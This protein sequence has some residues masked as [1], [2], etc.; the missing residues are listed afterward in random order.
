MSRFKVTIEIREKVGKRKRNMTSLGKWCGRREMIK[1]EWK[2]LI[3]RKKLSGER[4]H[5]SLFFKPR[6][7]LTLSVRAELQFLSSTLKVH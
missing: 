5:K 6:V 7:Q 3:I 2:G 4:V 1:I